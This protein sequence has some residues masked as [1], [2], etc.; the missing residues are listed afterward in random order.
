MSKKGRLEKAGWSSGSVQDFL[1]LSDQEMALIE[2]KR[3]LVRMIRETRES[4]RVTQHALAKLL[5]SSQSRVAKMEGASPDVS[6]D[7]IVRALFV[8]GVT[9]KKMGRF[10]ALTTSR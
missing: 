2:L 1:G 5:E 10:I 4:N 7:L 9:P 3:S 6:L 8:L